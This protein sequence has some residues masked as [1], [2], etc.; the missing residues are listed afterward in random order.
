[1]NAAI[2]KE[3]DR[4]NEAPFQKKDGSRHSVFLEEELPFFTAA[5]QISI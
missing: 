3:L 4:F 5:S 2:R 1:M